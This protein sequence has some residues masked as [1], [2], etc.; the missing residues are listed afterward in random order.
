MSIYKLHIYLFQI[1]KEKI[2]IKPHQSNLSRAVLIK[3]IN[4]LADPTLLIGPHVVLFNSVYDAIWNRDL[5]E[6]ESQNDWLWS[7]WMYI[8]WQFY[9]TD[10]HIDPGTIFDSVFLC[11]YWN[12]IQIDQLLIMFEYNIVYAEKYAKSNVNITTKNVQT[13][14]V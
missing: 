5:K 8:E 6:K 14:K 10:T 9:C 11:I 13:K 4:S 7:I 2:N 3:N 12:M 1:K